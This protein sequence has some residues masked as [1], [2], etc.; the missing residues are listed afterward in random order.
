MPPDLS[1]L[2]SATKKKHGMT[3][4][5]K[6][7]LFLPRQRSTVKQ[8]LVLIL[9]CNVK[10]YRFNGEDPELIWKRQNLYTLTVIHTLLMFVI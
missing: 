6:I 4:R 7:E 1:R 9:T 2:C 5:A 3:L 8:L 10:M